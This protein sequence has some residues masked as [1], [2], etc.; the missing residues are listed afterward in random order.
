MTSSSESSRTGLRLKAYFI[1]IFIHFVHSK[2]NSLLCVSRLQFEARN[3]NKEA[4]ERAVIEA[5]KK[6]EQQDLPED[7]SQS[8][9]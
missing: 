2:K 7:A 3:Q 6:R 1:I 5:M 4:K 9:Q 8:A